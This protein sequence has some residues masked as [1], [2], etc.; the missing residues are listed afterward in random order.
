VNNPST[1]TQILNQVPGYWRFDA[2]A[3]YAWG[4]AEFQVNVLNITNALYYAQ[5]A[6]SRAV[7]AEERVVMLGAKLKI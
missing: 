7:P 4:N 5:V 1:A 6:G 2:F 3:G